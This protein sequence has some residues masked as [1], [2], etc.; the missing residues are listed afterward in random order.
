MLRINSQ[1]AQKP[2]S[3]VLL[4]RRDLSNGQTP[5]EAALEE[6]FAEDLEA[7]LLALYLL[8]MRADWSDMDGKSAEEIAAWLLGIYGSAEAARRAL[9]QILYR[10]MVSAYNLGGQMALNDLGFM[11]RF[12]LTNEQILAAIRAR[13]EM[14]VSVDEDA[15]ESLIRTT[16]N[17][18]AQKVEREQRNGNTII[19]AVAT[20]A[21]LAAGRSVIRSIMI[22][23]TESV[24]QSRAAVIW[25]M[26]R[27]GLRNFI[28]RC[29]PDVEELCTTR[30]CIPHC[31]KRFR[32]KLTG[33]IPQWARLPKHPRCRCWHKP[34]KRGW[35]RPDQPYTGA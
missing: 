1:I 19:A 21:A 15:D 18:I 4:Q 22:A 2:S 16:A 17:E 27:N 29:E 32:A 31:G 35:K 34:D 20:I 13:A 33:W 6:A 3:Q 30:V 28:Y 23:E 12:N 5:E 7:A 26:V 14:L 10:Y 9:E 8:A 25:T 11:A 24:M